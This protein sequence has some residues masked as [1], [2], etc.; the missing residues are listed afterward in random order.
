M[1]NPLY[2][3][4][5]GSL[6]GD[7]VAMPVHWYY[8]TGALDRDYGVIHAYVA[9]RNP[10][11]DSI[12]WRSHY[13]PLHANGDILHEQARYWG[14]RGIHYHQFLAA[15]ENTLNLKLARELFH[16]IT[17]GKHYDPAAWLEHY[18]A[19][20]HDPQWHRDTYIEEYHRAFFT[21][22]SRGKHPGHCGVEDVHIGG[23]A[24]VPALCAALYAIGIRDEHTVRTTVQTHISLTHR[25]FRVLDAADVLTRLMVRLNDQA[26]LEEA[27]TE[28]ANGWVSLDQ[29]RRWSAYPDREVVGTV[30]S[31]ACYIDDA[32]AAS[33]YL[34]WQ[35]RHD[36]SGGVCANAM[37]GG[38]NCHRGVVVGSILGTIH[39][40]PDDW[41]KGLYPAPPVP[42]SSNRLHR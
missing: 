27:L 13:Q 37:V 26:G 15:G 6:V 38:D 1:T 14:Q 9:P 3:G 28:V 36:F 8:N 30:L 23:L 29:F 2:S 42:V 12:L 20:M 39:G 41:V 32:F 5:L 16:W 17:A 31:P 7:A 11:P 22:L 18:I 34:A 19:C 10:H 35:H 21:N 4:F 24:A 33:L 25:H 40:I